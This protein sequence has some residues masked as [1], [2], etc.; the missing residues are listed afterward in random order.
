MGT[1]TVLIVGL[2]VGILLVGIYN[3]FANNRKRVLDAWNNVDAALRRRYDLIPS[4]VNI[5]KGY[6]IHDQEALD[7][8]IAARNSATE[9]P[10]G[11]IEEQIKAE[12]AV[13]ENLAALFAWVAVY[14]ELEASLIYA[15]LQQRFDLAE[16]NLDRS[17]N[18]YNR[19]ILENNTYGESFPGILFGRIFN[20]QHF[21]VFEADAAKSEIVTTDVVGRIEEGNEQ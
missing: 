14:P 2:I 9:V 20:Y 7:R 5:I 19:T 3:R 17:R 13:Q 8:L 12:A 18:F 21:I 15:D 16:E 10:S 1:I 11:E 6:A 4:L